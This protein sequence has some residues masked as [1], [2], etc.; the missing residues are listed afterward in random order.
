MLIL[1]EKIILENSLKCGN[2]MNF[3]DFVEFNS[4]DLDTIFVDKMF[5]NLDNNIPIY[6]DQTMIEYFG[7]SGKLLDQRKRIY[8]LIDTNF[9]EYQDKLWWAYSNKKYIEYR[10]SLLSGHPVNKLLDKPIDI[11]TV[12]PPT[13]TGRGKSNA[14]HTLIMPKLFKE[15]LMLCQTNKG[16]QIRRFYIDMLDTIDIYLKYQNTQLITQKDDKIDELKQLILDSDKRREE[17]EKKQE[18]RYN[19]LI[20]TAETTQEILIETN[21]DLKK[22]SPERVRLSNVPQGKH[23][24]FM[25]LKDTNDTE[26]PYYVIRCQSVSIKSTVKKAKQKFPGIIRLIKFKHPSSVDFWNELK[27][28]LHYF[29]NHSNTSNWFGIKDI[30]EDEFIIKVKKIN[31]DRLNA[32]S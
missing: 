9:L 14:R 8:E 11:D 6:M 25:I 27:I 3:K 7:Y 13:Q 18:E 19:K 1:D 17:A 12:Y 22:I 24:V 4:I 5:H 21:A 29:I 15:M 31:S 28:T 16:K 23:H 26:V 2:K 10:E 20:S 32:K 30:S